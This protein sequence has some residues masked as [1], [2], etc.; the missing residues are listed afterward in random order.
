M[1]PLKNLP[2]ESKEEKNQMSEEIISAEEFKIKNLERM[3]A[4]RD[5]TI[6]RL[7]REKANVK[8]FAQMGYERILQALNG[9]L[10]KPIL[11]LLDN[12]NNVS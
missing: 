12:P 8:Y 5:K 10:E 9:E 1:L 4:D 3:L 2:M 11:R 7:L 6:E